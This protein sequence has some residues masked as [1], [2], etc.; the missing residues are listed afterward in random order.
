MSNVK[1]C[2]C[3]GVLTTPGNRVL[4]QDRNPTVRLNTDDIVILIDLPNSMS[5]EDICQHCIDEVVRSKFAGAC[6]L[7]APYQPARVSGFVQD[8]KIEDITLTKEER[9]ALSL[10]SHRLLKV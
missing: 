6:G 10:L 7:L 9:K 8:G 2:D 1:K 3:C 4:Q 5:E